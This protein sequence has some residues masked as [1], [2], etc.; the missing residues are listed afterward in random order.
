LWLL[1][2]G[3]AAGQTAQLE[4][5]LPEQLVQ[6]LR[7]LPPILARTERKDGRIDPVEQR[8][9]A[10]YARLREIGQPAVPA[11]AR[12]L[13]DPDV[14]IRRN[15]ALFLIVGGMGLWSPREP[16]FD[17]QGLVPALTAALSDSDPTTRGFAAQAISTV[18][19][20]AAPAVPA[21]I[22]LLNNADEGS[23]TGA[24]LGLTG[25]GPAAKAA[26]PALR[27]A[28]SDSSDNVRGFAQRAIEKIDVARQITP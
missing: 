1:C 10:V 23:R 9:H 26:L 25:I 13:A 8:R 16:R 22:A 20:A 28:L 19:A 15:V 5:A 17:L 21:L 4:S 2:T 18:G 3:V 12:G 27:R 24:C 11:L 6:E 14:G 7:N